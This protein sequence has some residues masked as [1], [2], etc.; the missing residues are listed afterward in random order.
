MNRTTTN[1]DPPLSLRNAA[2]CEA[3]TA[4]GRA[5][6]VMDARPEESPDSDSSPIDSRELND[7]LGDDDAPLDIHVDFDDFGVESDVA[8]TVPRPWHRAA[9]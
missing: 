7:G 1:T 3:L 5:V 6:F 4:A 9:V 8:P 2:L